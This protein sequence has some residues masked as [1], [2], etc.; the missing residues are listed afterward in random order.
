MTPDC[1]PA[2]L[3]EVE[4]A[5]A[6]L[7][8]NRPAFF[9]AMD[10]ALL[11][12]L[13]EGLRRASGDSAVR[14]VVITGA[15]KA[16]CAGADLQEMHRQAASVDVQESLRDFYHPVILAMRQMPKPILG[17]VNGVAAGAGMSLVLACDVVIAGESARFVQAFSRIGLVPDCGSTWFLPRLVGEMR[18]RA[19]SLL[20]DPIDAQQARQMGIVWEVCPDHDLATAAASLAQRLAGAAPRACALIK[21]ALAASP[22]QGLAEQLETEGALQAQAFRTDDFR[23]GVSAFLEKRSPRFKGS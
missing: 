5:I 19:L 14:A 9:N 18:A 7:T 20:A 2:V 16:F 22:N 3:Y 8:L 4:N 12:G 17:V 13:R 15:G 1:P 6:T 10:R 11:L 21:Q 23:E